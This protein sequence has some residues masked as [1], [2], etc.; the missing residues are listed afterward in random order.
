MLILGPTIINIV[1]F[2]NSRD[3]REENNIL[4]VPWKKERPGTKT[5]WRLLRRKGG[6]LRGERYAGTDSY[7]VRTKK[8]GGVQKEF[9]VDIGRRGGR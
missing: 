6:F 4:V 3:D 5:Q 1:Y 8:Q 7:R 9:A 2:E